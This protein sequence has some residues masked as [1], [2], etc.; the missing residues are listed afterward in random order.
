M[1][2]LIELIENLIKK[3]NDQERPILWKSSE[4]NE[5]EFYISYQDNLVKYIIKIRF[6]PLPLKSYT[7]TIE[8]TEDI[9]SETISIYEDEYLYNKIHKLFLSIRNSVLLKKLKNVDLTE[10]IKNINRFIMNP[11]Q[12]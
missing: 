1:N 6:S 10:A 3:T 11:I 5:D 12:Q 8:K 2:E 4:E 9:L 7:L